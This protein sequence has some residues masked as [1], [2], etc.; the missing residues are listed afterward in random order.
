MQNTTKRNLAKIEKVELRE[1]W[2]HEAYD[3]TKWL[4]KEENL[5][6]LGDEIGI[7]ISLEE[8]EANVG[9]FNVDI[10][11]KEENS[12]RK[13][14][15]ENQLETTNHDHLGKII[16]YASGYDAEIIIWIVKDAREEHKKA[17][18]W[19]NNHSDEKTNFFLI[20]IELWRIENSNPAPKFEILES[21]NEWKKTIKVTPPGDGITETKLKQLEFWTEFKKYVENKNKKIKLRKPRPQYWYDIAIGRS[22][23]FITLLA[24]SRENFVVCGLY[25]VN[26]KNLFDYLNSKKIDIESEIG[27][28]L[29]TSYATKDSKII[30]KKQIPDI[31]NPKNYEEA[32]EWLYKNALLFKDVFSK[33]LKE[34]DE[35]RNTPYDLHTRGGEP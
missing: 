23:A 29:E 3:F 28:S 10:L 18:E 32:F 17:I 2:N 24:N 8:V 20:K 12:E 34:F 4:A 9:K 1:I 11:A 13:I 27:F 5:E 31:F 6:L 25:I 35:E 26:N 14:I 16:T 21:P 33:Y 7:D 19:L 30:T 15:I 22:D